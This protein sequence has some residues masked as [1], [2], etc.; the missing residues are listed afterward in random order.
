MVNSVPASN[1]AN[2]PDTQTPPANSDGQ[3]STLA[4]QLKQDTDKTFQDYMKQIDLQVK[5]AT[6]EQIA[7]N[8]KDI[9]QD[10]NDIQSVANKIDE[11]DQKKR[12]ENENPPQSNGQPPPNSGPDQSKGTNPNTDPRSMDTSDVSYD[13]LSPQDKTSKASVDAATAQKEFDDAYNKDPHSEETRK[14]YIRLAIANDRQKYYQTTGPDY[15]GLSDSAKLQIASYNVE[16]SRKR[17]LNDTANNI[18]AVQA[19]D[20]LEQFYKDKGIYEQISGK[21]YTASPFV[22]DNT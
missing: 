11:E 8:K 15:P 22:M 9:E 18:P 16:F 19:N 6:P 20:D 14:A 4:M 21:T 13:G 7:A 5:G 17:Y 2:K 3:A 1:P 12:Q 10:L